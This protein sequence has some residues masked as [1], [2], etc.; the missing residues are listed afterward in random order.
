MKM[1][2]KETRGGPLASRSCF[3]DTS[4]STTSTRLPI[5]GSLSSTSTNGVLAGVALLATAAVSRT[6]RGLLLLSH[7]FSAAALAK[8][9][10][11][12]DQ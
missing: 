8:M 11:A 1:K 6:G 12:T 3:N 2:M 10:L 4:T 9:P 7:R 5:Q